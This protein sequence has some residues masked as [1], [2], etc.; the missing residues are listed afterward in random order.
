MSPIIRKKERTRE[1][2]RLREGGLRASE[3]RKQKSQSI[4]NIKTK[5]VVRDR[6]S[7]E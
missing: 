5:P 1:R 6:V 4:N 2:V 3:E 7:R